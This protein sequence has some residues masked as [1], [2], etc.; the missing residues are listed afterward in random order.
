MIHLSIVKW[1]I[2]HVDFSESAYFASEVGS[3]V[4]DRTLGSSFAILDKDRFVRDQSLGELIV[5][6]DHD[7]VIKLCHGQPRRTSTRVCRDSAGLAKAEIEIQGVVYRG[8]N[9]NCCRSRTN[10]R[11]RCSP[12]TYGTGS[13]VYVQKICLA[14]NHPFA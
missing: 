3:S 11:S 14:Y 7:H 8:H 13:W 2:G 9:A 4:T 6:A 5:E 10:A 1:M 12:S